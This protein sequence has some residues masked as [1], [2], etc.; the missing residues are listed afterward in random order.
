M[1]RSIQSR[2]VLTETKK[3]GSRTTKIPDTTDLKPEFNKQKNLQWIEGWHC[4]K[5]QCS[6]KK[7]GR[8][9]IAP[10]LKRKQILLP[11]A[12]FGSFQNPF[13]L[14]KK[15][16]SSEWENKLVICLEHFSQFDREN[17]KMFGQLSDN[18]Q[19]F[20]RSKTLIQSRIAA[21]QQP[22]VNLF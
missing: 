20:N 7:S 16:L 3:K 22:L 17:Y 2:Q 14:E 21:F 13:N 19:L 1:T 4:I 8:M 9:A 10:I 6:L 5:R 11:S 15:G 18:C 12:L